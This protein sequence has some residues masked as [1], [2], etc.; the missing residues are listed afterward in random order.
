MNIAF[1]DGM[2]LQ[3]TLHDNEAT[4]LSKQ[5]TGTATI[6]FYNYF[7]KYRLSPEKTLLKLSYC[8]GDKAVEIV[9]E[10]LLVSQFFSD[11]IDTHQE[12][13]LAAAKDALVY[14]YNLIQRAFSDIDAG[15][16]VHSDTDTQGIERSRALFEAS[17]FAITFALLE[18]RIV[19]V[20]TV[21]NLH[22]YLLL[23]LYHSNLSPNSTKKIA[24]CPCC[25]RV[26]RLSQ[27]NKVYCSKYCKDKNIRANSRK[28]PY[29]SE[30]RYLQQYNNRQLNKW[31]RN[32]VDSSPQAQKL[33]DA[34]HAWNEWARSEYEQVSSISDHMQRMTV[35]EF[36][37]CLK[38]RWKALTQ[39][40]K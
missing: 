39:D 3:V 36:G 9:S 27:R 7:S 10:Q 38:E 2:L 8:L 12:N 13:N 34:Y 26:F 30:Y 31:R 14:T 5:K 37:E 1:Y 32:M 6:D 33:Q 35:E 25:K 28:G 23:D 21:N 11:C 22:E 18:N 20:Y 24:V 19:P 29:Y 17:Q 40:L 4:I 15:L 16:S